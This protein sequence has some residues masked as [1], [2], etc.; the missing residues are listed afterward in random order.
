MDSRQVKGNNR[1]GNS[2]ILGEFRTWFSSGNI[3]VS[4]GLPIRM[5]GKFWKEGTSTCKGAV[6][7]L[8]TVKA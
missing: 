6:S 2:Y 7:I 4:V 3:E 5:T 1:T 8:N